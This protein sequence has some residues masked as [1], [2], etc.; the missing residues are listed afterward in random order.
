MREDVE[1]LV[2]G[3]IFGEGVEGV[4]GCWVEG[5][6]GPFSLGLEEEGEGVAAYVNGVD[7]GVLDT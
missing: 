4:A 1:A 3:V 5:R 2:V 7:Y 6:G